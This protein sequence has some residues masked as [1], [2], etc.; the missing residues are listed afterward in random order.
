MEQFYWLSRERASLEAAQDAVSA[1]ARL[2]LVWE[3]RCRALTAPVLPTATP[4]KHPMLE[5]ASTLALVSALLLAA[6]VTMWGMLRGPL[7]QRLDGSRASN[8]GPAELAL[9]TLVLA[10]ALSFVAAVWAIVAWIVA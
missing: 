1:E 7:L 9:K 5:A 2:I 3:P 6:S 4:R 8:D 10:F